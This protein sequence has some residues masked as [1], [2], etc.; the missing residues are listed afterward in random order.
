MA[1]G[2][3]WPAPVAPGRGGLLSCPEPRGAS[4]RRRGWGGGRAAGARSGSSGAAPAPPAARGWGHHPAGRVTGGYRCTGESGQLT[5]PPTLLRIQ[6]YKNVLDF[7]FASPKIARRPSFMSQSD[8]DQLA[9]LL[10]IYTKEQ[11]TLGVQSGLYLNWFLIKDGRWQIHLH[12]IFH[13]FDQLN[14]WIDYLEEYFHQKL[15]SF[16]AKFI[17]NTNHCP[18]SII[19]ERE[20]W[21]HDYTKWSAVQGFKSV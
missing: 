3:W 21:L 14:E 20:V 11:A 4:C 12:F 13:N 18:C 2:T 6:K 10:H 7:R 9:E 17:F 19:R 1:P 5:D 15:P 16:I 8:C